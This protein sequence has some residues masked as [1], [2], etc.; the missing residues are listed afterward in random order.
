MLAERRRGPLCLL[1]A[2]EL[3][4][5][6]SAGPTQPLAKLSLEASKISDA[7]TLRGELGSESLIG[8]ALLLG[9]G[10]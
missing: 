7:G 8:F 1:S 2:L 6:K 3:L 9:L 4:G 5:P 10:A